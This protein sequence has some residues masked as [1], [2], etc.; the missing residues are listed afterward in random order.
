MTHAC[1][2]PSSHNTRIVRCGV[3]LGHLASYQTLGGGLG[4]GRGLGKDQG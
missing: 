2:P 4:L 1:N 3:R